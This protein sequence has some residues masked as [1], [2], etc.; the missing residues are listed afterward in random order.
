M[1]ALPSHQ[2]PEHSCL[3]R[4]E[5]EEQ[6]LAMVID[7]YPLTFT[8]RFEVPEQSQRW[9]AAAGKMHGSR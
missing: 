9:A 2:E 6:E 7:S 8:A 4:P 1:T 3:C 5:S